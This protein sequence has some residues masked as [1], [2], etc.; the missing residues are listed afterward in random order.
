MCIYKYICIHTHTHTYVN[1]HGA[2]SMPDYVNTHKWNPDLHPD[3]F[4]YYNTKIFT[5]D[6]SI[7]FNGYTLFHYKNVLF[8]I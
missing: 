7:L 4:I 2:Y 8:I 5:H 3:F 6:L 1:V